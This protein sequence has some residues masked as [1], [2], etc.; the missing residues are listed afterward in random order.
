MF[1]ARLRGGKARVVEQLGPADYLQQ[2]F[3]LPAAGP[4]RGI[5]VNIVVG[6]A[7]TAGEYAAG[8][9]RC[10]GHAV[11]HSAGG[12]AGFEV[13]SPGGAA[14]VDDHVLHGY[15]DSLPEAGD[16]ALVECGQDPQGA[17]DAGPAV[18]QVG[19]GLQGRPVGFACD[20]GTAAGRLADGVEGGEIC[21]GAVATE[22]FDLRVDQSPVQLA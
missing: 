5:D 14:E 22:A 7:G 12:S 2:L 3:P 4:A 8:G 17:V 1:V 16:G 9:D 18:G 19:A 15:L 10:Q 20:G 11:A 6:S 21:I 13:L